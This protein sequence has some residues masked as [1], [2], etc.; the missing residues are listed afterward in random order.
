MKETTI[1]ALSLGANIGEPRV[2]IARALK[3]IAASP[4]LSLRAVSS[5]WSTRPVGYVDQPDFTNL[6]ALIECERSPERLLARLRAIERVLGRRVRQK[7]REREI[8]I[9][10][11]LFG[12][13]VIELPDLV[14]PHPEMHR[15]AFVLAPLAQIAPDMM[16][17]VIGQAI[18]RL[19]ENVADPGEATKEVEML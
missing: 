18:I 4:G 2:T 11:V 10:I 5:Y 1:V 17:P 19:L 16:H 13:R 14:I 9:D 12:D 15:R 6:A 3:L 8:D 7:W